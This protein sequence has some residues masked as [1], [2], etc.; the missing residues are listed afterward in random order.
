MPSKVVGGGKEKPMPL[1]DAMSRK[2]RQLRELI[3]KEKDLGQ[4]CELV[5]AINVLLSHIDRQ[6]ARLRQAKRDI[7]GREL[8]R[9]S[10]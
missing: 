2:V 1:N 9:S 7:K 6:G 10:G 5:V 8:A 4:L 3:A